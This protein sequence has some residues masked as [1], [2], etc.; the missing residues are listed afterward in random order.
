[1]QVRARAASQFKS[2]EV[3]PYSA[4]VFVPP[5]W[6]RRYSECFGFTLEEIFEFGARS[7]DD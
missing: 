4:A 5:N 3:L 2:G 1:M 7:F 6:D